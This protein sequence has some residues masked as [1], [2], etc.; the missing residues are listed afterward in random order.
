MPTLKARVRTKG[1]EVAVGV[2]RAFLQTLKR[3]YRSNPVCGMDLSPAM[4]EKT[5]RLAFKT[6]FFKK[7]DFLEPL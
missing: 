4:I 1:L 2:G 3:V 6:S 7:L 5:G